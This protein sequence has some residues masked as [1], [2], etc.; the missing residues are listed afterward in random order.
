VT[1]VREKHA[2]CLK[3]LREVRFR[4]PKASD[5][6]EA[7]HTIGAA[8]ADVL[9]QH[10]ALSAAEIADHI[11]AT[12]RESTI[13]PYPFR[14]KRW[15]SVASSEV[16]TAGGRCRRPALGELA[17]R[18]PNDGTADE[19]GGRTTDECVSAHPALT[20]GAILA[21]GGVLRPRILFIGDPVAVGRV[22]V[23]ASL[24]GLEREGFGVLRFARALGVHRLDPGFEGADFVGHLMHHAEDLGALAARLLPS[25]E[26]GCGVLAEKGNWPPEK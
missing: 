3:I 6:E 8:I 15:K 20:F 5:Q 21:R 7:R 25:S 18:S 22:S 9:G 26:A 1:F 10:G 23:K 17:H 13:E 12:G 2:S 14:F 4:K 16:R 19:P 11:R 24:R